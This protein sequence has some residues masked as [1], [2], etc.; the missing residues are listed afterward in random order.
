MITKTP[1]GTLAPP[2]T[3]TTEVSPEIWVQSMPFGRSVVPAS[4]VTEP[5]ETVPS[6][7]A[8]RLVIRVDCLLLPFSWSLLPPLFVPLVLKNP[9][10]FLL[11]FRTVVVI[12]GLG[13]SVS[14]WLRLGSVKVV[15]EVVPSNST[16]EDDPELGVPYPTLTVTDVPAFRAPNVHSRTCPLG[17]HVPWVGVP[18]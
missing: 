9:P 17:L 2:L 6:K 8:A 16:R 13:T 18:T 14:P 15:P 7:P 10:K 12:A 5:S 3:F 1:P 11:L 4:A